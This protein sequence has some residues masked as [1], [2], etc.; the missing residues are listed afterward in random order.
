MKQKI[1][2]YIKI[3]VGLGMAYIFSVLLMSSV[4]ENNSP[5]IRNDIP[6]RIQDRY[7]AL[8]GKP[9]VDVEKALKDVPSI[10]VSKGVYAKQKGNVVYT[11][12]KLN[13]IEMIEYTFTVKGKE[14]KIRVPK[15]QSPPTKDFLEK[16]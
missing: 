13:E 12:I 16:L 6:S 7:I 3:L 5:L 4:F 11:E 14:I 15:G 8:L 10:P 1:A 2:T 9:M